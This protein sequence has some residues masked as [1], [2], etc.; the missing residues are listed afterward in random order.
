MVRTIE[1][2]SIFLSYKTKTKLR[3]MADLLKA[4]SGKLSVMD[5]LMIAGAKS[6]SER[7][8]AR[9]VGNG[10]LMSGA[11]K[12][13]ISI[14][15]ISGVKGKVGDILGTAM[16]VDGG[17]DIITSFLGGAITNIGAGITGGNDN[18]VQVM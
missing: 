17:E 16:M 13:G 12:M 15:L 7:I 10:T 8:L 4:K 14:A 6:V 1:L 3:T 9:F 2:S 5:A 18:K 11:L